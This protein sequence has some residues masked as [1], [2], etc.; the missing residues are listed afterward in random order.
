MKLFYGEEGRER[1]MC[2]PE[3]V[4]MDVFDDLE[5][6]ENFEHP[7]IVNEFK[8]MEIELSAKWVVE[9]ILEKLDDELGDPDGDYTQ[10]TEAMIKSAEAL[11]ETIKKEYHVWMCEPTGNKIE[12]SQEDILKIKGK[13]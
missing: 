4:V 12:Y 8:P 9:E 13:E 6:I 10:P 3:E 5:T 1:L 11:V 2:D 7:F